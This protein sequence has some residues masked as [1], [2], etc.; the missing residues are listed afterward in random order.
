MRGMEDRFYVGLGGKFRIL[1]SNT[2]FKDQKMSQIET[3]SIQM[4]ENQR[5]NSKNT[6]KSPL[7]LIFHPLLLRKDQKSC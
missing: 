7:L 2:Q 4:Y 1:Y 5:N 6:Q 3:K